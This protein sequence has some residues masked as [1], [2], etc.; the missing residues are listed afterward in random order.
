MSNT[1]VTIADV[2]ERA[3]VSVA[4]VSKVING[5]W[6][7][8][9]A[10]SARVK[11]VIEELGY[12]SS[13]GARSLRSSASN[14]IGVLVADVEPFSA[15]VLKGVSA[16]L[17]GTGYEL[18]V[19]AGIDH[20]DRQG[21]E[22]T[23]VA[24]VGGTLADGMILV[25]PTVASVP[26]EA[27]MVVVDPHVDAAGGDLSVVSD[28]EGGAVA[29]VQH[30]VTLGHTR[31]GLLTGRE[32]LVSACDREAGYRRAL[33]DAGIEVDESLIAVGRYLAEPSHE[34]VLA[35]LTRADRPTAVFAAN[36]LSALETIRVA[37]ELGL[38]VPE[39]LSVVGFDDIP[40][41]ATCDPPLTTVDQPLHAMGR[42]AVE[43][44]LA[45]IE[46]GEVKSPPPLAVELVVRGST[47][48]PRD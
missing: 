9:E 5:R 32:G 14:I 45:S 29:A 40:E 28:N 48:P 27:P 26:S 6:G 31:I 18:L 39:D 37:E 41:A 43:V 3:G 22:K 38:K 24:R 10:T 23:Y 35:M 12:A 44:L 34:S 20:Q 2:A 47:A 33:A 13:L 25:T 16:G 7:V 42:A 36:D 8:A 30:L 19:Y 11:G 17:R 1:R 46:G 15:E 21:W 4:T